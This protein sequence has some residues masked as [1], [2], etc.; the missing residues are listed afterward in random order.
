[1]SKFGSIIAVLFVLT[2]LISRPSLAQQPQPYPD[3]VPGD[4]VVKFRSPTA[5]PDVRQRLR[6]EGISLL[7]ISQ[8]GR[9][10]RVQVKPGS[11]SGMIRA[12]AVR[13]DVEFATYNYRI[14]ALGDPND[15]EYSNQW[16]LNN[17][18]Q[19]GGTLDADIDAPEAWAIY[20]GSGNKTVA[21]ID[22]G[23]DLD[24]PD[25]QANIVA[26]YDF[27]NADA[28]ADDDNGHGTHVAGIAAAVGNN[29]QGIAGVSWNAKIM[30][31][32]VLSASG[33]GGTFDLAEAIYFAADNGANVINMSLGASC[34]TPWPNVEA[35]VNYA[36]SKGV[37]LVAASGNANNAVYCPAVIEGVMAVGATD[38]FD[39]RWQMSAF[40]GSNYG[41][42]L[43]VSAPGQSIYSTVKD[44][45]YDY[46]T[47]TSM[48]G[49]HVAGLAT[50]VWSFGP[51]LTNNQVSDL[52]RST[53]DDL[54]AAGWD[55][56]FG[57][58]RINAWRALDAISLQTPA[59]LTLLI[60]DFSPTAP[61]SIQISTLN[62]DI[63]SWEAVISPGVAWL[64]LQSS[65]S[66][67]ISAAS[68]PVNVTVVANSPSSYGTYLT[69]LVITGTTGTGAKT[70]PRETEIRLIYVPKLNR[71]YLPLVAID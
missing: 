54:G 11:E 63:I 50:L 9:S 21:I 26:G 2:F 51:T 16:G 35:A 70:N 42:A 14:H 60:D 10:A 61:G 5:G 3:F 66:G 48:A 57:Y 13:S 68:T 37:L 36:Q 31:L 59:Q 41:D 58:G 1:M 30:P 23:V 49:P 12:L 53:S 29:N 43:E 40:Q 62:P 69:K 65:P 67:K 55:P 71:S 25:L 19:L 8:D 24:H 52:I 4:V 15:P 45:G 56:Y 38:N 46:K 32:K 20:S 7:Q 27:V 28:S 17:I 18:G 33:S 39:A 64:K 47:G 44:G 6:A 22:T 34:S